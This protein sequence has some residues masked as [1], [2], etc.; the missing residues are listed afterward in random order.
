MKI[1]LSIIINAFILFLMTYLLGENAEK[2]I[3]A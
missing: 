3:T 1:I 2:G